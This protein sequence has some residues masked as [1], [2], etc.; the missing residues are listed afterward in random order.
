[1]LCWPAVPFAGTSSPRTGTFAESHLP[2]SSEAD[3][4][5][6]SGPVRASAPI[7]VKGSHFRGWPG[8]RALIEPFTAADRYTRATARKALRKFPPER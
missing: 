4:D 1:M 3:G 7:V 8:T 6:P 2:G 5:R